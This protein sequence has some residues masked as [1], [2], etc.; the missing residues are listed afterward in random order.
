MRMIRTPGMETTAGTDVM[1][2]WNFMCSSLKTDLILRQLACHLGDWRNRGRFSGKIYFS[3]EKVQ[4]IWCWTR[5][6]CVCIQP[7]P[8]QLESVGKLEVQR[9][10]KWVMSVRRTGQNHR[11]QSKSMRALKRKLMVNH[12]GKFFDS[13][14]VN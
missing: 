6:R 1:C 11:S 13:I 9:Y 10:G 7:N 5:L 8:E 4:N 3:K 14:H 12:F 2:P